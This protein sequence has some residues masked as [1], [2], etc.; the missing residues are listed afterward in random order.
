MWLLDYLNNVKSND[1][2]IDNED[3]QEAQYM[4]SC[5]PS[6]QISGLGKIPLS[7]MNLLISGKYQKRVRQKLVNMA[8]DRYASLP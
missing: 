7:V 5:R 1:N 8:A 6:K 2:Q 4:K 3:F